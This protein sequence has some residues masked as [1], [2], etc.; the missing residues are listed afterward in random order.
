MLWA[1]RRRA[2]TRLA[3]R[4]PT[5]LSS[6]HT[7]SRYK[8]NIIVDGNAA[9]SQRLASM[10]QSGSTLLKQESPS[11]E[12][13]YDDLQPYVHYVPLSYQLSDVVRKADWCRRHDEA[14]RGIAD[15]AAQYARSA[16]TVDNI[17]CYWHRL[18]TRYS[19]LMKFEPVS[20][21]TYAEHRLRFKD[22]DG[23]RMGH[24]LECAHYAQ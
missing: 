13:F 4:N 23:W 7:Y 17:A 20:N 22:F 14:A 1:L 2:T 6:H 12:F 5:D 24:N 8:Y 3:V 18:L 19:A 10:L 9:P 15:N 16:L 21:A 11:V